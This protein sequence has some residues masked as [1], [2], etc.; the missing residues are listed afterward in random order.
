MSV[1]MSYRNEK[2]RKSKKEGG[3]GTADFI[4]SYMVFIREHKELARHASRLQHVER[5][6][7][8]RN[9]QSVV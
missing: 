3:G 1:K 7:S 4:S 2:F 6:Q 5:S 9:G 8:L